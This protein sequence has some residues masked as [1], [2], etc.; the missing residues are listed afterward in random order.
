M[1]LKIIT[2]SSSDYTIEEAKNLGI[3]LIPL[4]FY[5][6][7]KAY[8]DGIDITKDQFYNLLINEKKFPKTSQPTPDVFENLFLKSKEAN[9]T[10]LVIPLGIAFSGT[11]YNACLAKET[12]GY[13]DIHIVDSCTT[14]AGL[15]ILVEHALKLNNEG[16]TI[17]EIVDAINELKH[18]IAVIGTVNTLDYLVKG[19]RVSQSAAIIGNMLNIKPAITLK[20]DGHIEV[21]AKSFGKLRADIFACK[22]F[23]ENEMDENFPIYY[24]YS[25]NKSNLDTLVEKLKKDNLYKEGQYINLSP[26]VGCHVGPNGYALVYVKK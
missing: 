3:E 19:G 21:I 22:F 5:F 18:R 16:K 1:K 4:T 9:E 17:E 8:K 15:R 11:Y 13:D 23:K 25:H 20:E 10:V 26:V 2:D 14:I 24:Y 6:D 12:V 7:D